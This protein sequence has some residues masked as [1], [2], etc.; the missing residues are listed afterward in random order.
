M[1]FFSC[2]LL[3]IWYVYNGFDQVSHYFLHLEKLHRNNQHKQIWK[4]A[5]QYNVYKRTSITENS[6]F[7]VLVYNFEIF[8]N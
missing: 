6:S 4:K 8:N 5:S 2:E 7:G 1:Y 3:K